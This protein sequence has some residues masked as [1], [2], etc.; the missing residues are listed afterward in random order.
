[1]STS[2]FLDTSPPASAHLHA[3]GLPVALDARNVFVFRRRTR[4]VLHG[5]SGVRRGACFQGQALRAGLGPRFS[6]SNLYRARV[7]G[8]QSRESSR[9]EG[10]LFGVLEMEKDAKSS[11]FDSPGYLSSRCSSSQLLRPTGGTN[12]HLPRVASNLTRSPSFQNKKQQTAKRRSHPHQAVRQV[13]QAHRDGGEGGGRGGSGGEHAAGAS[14]G[15]RQEAVR[16]RGFDRTEPE[17]RDGHEPGGL[18]GADV[19]GYVFYFPN[20]ASTFLP[21]LCEYTSH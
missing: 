8:T 11:V 20:P 4:G 10:A 1:M 16:P 6:P 2:S 7:H 9:E 19:R 15:G 14:A 21:P 12:S 17:A 3:P 5:K 13:R 18:H